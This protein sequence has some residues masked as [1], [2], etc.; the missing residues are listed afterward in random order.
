MNADIPEE[1]TPEWDELV[2]RGRRAKQLGDEIESGKTRPPKLWKATDLKG[3]A[4]P[5]F[6]ARNRIPQSA[7]T[8]LIGEEGLGKSLLWVMLVAAITT[9]K[10]L[11]EFELP[12][13]DPAYVHLAVTEDDW[14]TTVRPRLEVAGADL[15]YVRVIC[16]DVDGS[17][18]PTF[19]KDMPTITEADPA[20]VLVVVDAWLDTVPQ[21]MQVRNPQ[22][23]RNALHPWREA[24]NVTGAAV[25][26]LTHSNRVG[27]ANIR[28]RYG[29]TA[30]LRQKARMTLYCL[31][32]DEGHLIVGPDKANGA[33]NRTHASIFRILPVQHFEPTDDHDGTVPRLVF[34]QQSDR[35]ITQHL[36][37]DMEAEKARM[38]PVTKAEV[39]LREY[40][41][42]GGGKRLANDVYAAGKDSEYD[43]SKDQL[44]RAKDKIPALVASRE[45][46]QWWWKLMP[47]RQIKFGVINGEGGSDAEVS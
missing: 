46:D 5:Q 27:T 14:A 38:R 41:D 43:F 4:Q 18:A 35:T 40:I 3:T 28:D 12:A 44:K 7:I 24:A 23:A 34:V 36:Q 22:H 6:L 11:P 25:L 45:D 9:G 26:L 8:V 47:A 21:S 16:E 1:G 20:P 33:S 39:W 15:D 32:D 42:D 30:A 2:Q 19:P 13:R 31:G 37:D 29:A 17:G 10:P